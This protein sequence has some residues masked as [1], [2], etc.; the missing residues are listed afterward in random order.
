[1]SEE[2]Y[3]AIVVT[4]VA[5]EENMFD[6]QPDIPRIRIDSTHSYQKRESMLEKLNTYYTLAVVIA[7]LTLGVLGNS[8]TLVADATRIFADHL[9]LFQYD[10]AATPGKRLTEIITV[11]ITNVVL[12]LLFI[13]FLLTASG[14]AATM[15]FD[16]NRMYLLIGTALAMTAN[17]LQTLCHFRT[18]QRER[19]YN[20]TLYTGS[21]RNQLMHGFVYHFVAYFVLVSSLL[22]IVNKDY[23]IADVVTTYITSILI[24]TNIS[25]IGYQLYHEY[26][27]L[28]HPQDE[29]EPI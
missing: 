13:A 24:L 10:R 29:Y 16:I 5:M 26:F 15:D 18:W 23:I 7:Q 17:T 6:P 14:R 1:M 8:L 25:S 28:E 4:R 2:G 3:A 11:G 22:I 21:K 9:E 27:S 20:F 19:G 12:F